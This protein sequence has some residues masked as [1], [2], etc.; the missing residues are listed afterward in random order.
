MTIWK[1]IQEFKR[2]SHKR[3]RRNVVAF[4]SWPLL[5]FSCPVSATCSKWLNYKHQSPASFT[6]KIIWNLVQWK[7]FFNRTIVFLCFWF[8]IHQ[9]DGTLHLQTTIILNRNMLNS[10]F[11]LIMNSRLTDSNCEPRA[12][13]TSKKISVTDENHYVLM[14]LQLW[15]LQHPFLSPI[16]Q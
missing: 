16:I 10:Y 8:L 12:K 3:A 6:F 11:G 5:E 15:I 4:P 14:L 7:I 1:P 2:L 13:T 9:A